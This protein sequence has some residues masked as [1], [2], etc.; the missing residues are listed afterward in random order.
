[1][2]L[3][4]SNFGHAK[5]AEGEDP[6]EAARAAEARLDY[7]AVIN[8]A[9]AALELSNNSHERLVKLYELLGTANGVLNKVEEAV[10]A[11]THLL[12]IDPEYHLPR[13]LSPKVTKPFKEAGGFWLD[14]PGGLSVVPTLP[15]EIAAGQT[16]TVTVK[17]DDALTMATNVRLSY[18]REGDP[19]FTKVETPVGPNI[20]F[21]I[22]GDRLPVRGADYTVELSITALSANG[23]ELRTAGDAA[24]PLSV[25]VRVPHDNAVVIP[26]AAVVD[27][28]THPAE[29]KPLL[30]QWW[31][32]T[33]VGV[34]VV[35]AA[36]GGGLGW[37]YSQDRSHVGLTIS[38]SVTQ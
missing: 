34:V 15:H 12:A 6:Y 4:A 16:L 14:R 21:N 29:R 1:V 11:F 17:L 38:S 32:W 19:D 3:L 5:P 20:T 28:N 33:A 22:A 24:H 23:G 10:D 2:L 18:K 25:A 8:N 31:L 27:G 30:K 36:L 26:P 9:K 35:G 37:Y 13:G 7:R